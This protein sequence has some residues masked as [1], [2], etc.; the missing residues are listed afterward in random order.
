M[1]FKRDLK[2]VPRVWKITKKPTKKDYKQ[3]LKITLIGLLII[4]VIGFL[5]DVLWQ[6][7]LKNLFK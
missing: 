5:I 3:T 1:S 4:G 7:V 6:G 2:N